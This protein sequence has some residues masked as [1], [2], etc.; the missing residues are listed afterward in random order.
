LLYVIGVVLLVTAAWRATA[1]ST[2]PSAAPTGR[3][4]LTGRDL[5]AGYRLA[6]ADYLRASVTTGDQRDADRASQLL[7]LAER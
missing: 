5:H 7:Q 6:A 1:P 4:S 2:N 3:P